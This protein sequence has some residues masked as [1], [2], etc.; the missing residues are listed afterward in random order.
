MWGTY[1]PDLGVGGQVEGGATDREHQ[2]LQLG[3]V[4][5]RDLEETSGV[6]E[7][8]TGGAP[9]AVERIGGE[10][11]KGGASVDDSGSGRRDAGRAVLYGL[12]NT[13][14]EGGGRGGGDG[15]VRVYQLCSDSL[16]I[17]K[18]SRPGDGAGELGGI[19]TA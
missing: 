5:A 16:S 10:V 12:V 14:V 8:S 2:V 15:A 7:S 9:V 4:R 1:R 13:P 6:V 19:S 18:N 17:S 3:E 11:E